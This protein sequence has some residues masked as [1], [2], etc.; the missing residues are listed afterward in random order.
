MNTIDENM[1]NT[2]IHYCSLKLDFFCW[3][4]I[5]EG[6]HLVKK[7]RQKWKNVK[8]R[9]MHSQTV[10]CLF[11]LLNMCIFQLN[12]AKQHSSPSQLKQGVLHPVN[13]IHEL[14]QSTCSL[15]LF[16]WKHILIHA[17]CETERCGKWWD[18][19]VIESPTHTFKHGLYNEHQA[20]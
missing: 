14:R 4:N 16:T 13:C 6:A 18:G 8:G 7:V 17:D 3:S 9:I 5:V 1:I 20:T 2:Q 15:R 19:S 11:V 10:L 12:I